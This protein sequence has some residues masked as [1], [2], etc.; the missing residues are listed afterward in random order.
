[1]AQSSQNLNVPATLEGDTSF[2]SQLVT[3]DLC[4]S[5]SFECQ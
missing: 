3:C 1:M 4:A 5:H 2:G